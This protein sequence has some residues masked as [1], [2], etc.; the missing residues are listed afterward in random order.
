MVRMHRF[1]RTGVLTWVT[2]RS[3]QSWPVRTAD[4]DRGGRLAQRVHRRGHVP[5]VERAGHLQRAQPRPGWRVGGERGQLLHSP[6]RD[7]L[8]G[9][10]DV[11]GGQAVRLDRIEDLGLVA[12][13]HGGHP[14]GLDGRGLGHGLSPDLDQ[15]HR[16][17]G[18]EHPGQD[19]GAQLA[20]AVPGGRAGVHPGLVEPAEQRLRRGDG[21]R[22]QQRLGDRGI[23]DLL[24]AGA[25]PELDQVHPGQLGPG[26]E[27][28]GETREFQPGGEEARGLSALA[29]GGNNEHLLTL[30]CRS[31]LH[32]SQRARSLP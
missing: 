21:R 16:V 19:S 6:G 30:H 32:G 29:R 7:D 3:S 1:H 9:A 5:G 14:G 28:L 2:I 25:R 23:A 13:K 22:D 24:G 10:V 18:G 31:P 17:P 4:R 11:R 27:A 12:A 26:A 20:D 8:P 15:A